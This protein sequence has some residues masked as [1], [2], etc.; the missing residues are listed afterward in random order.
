MRRSLKIIIVCMKLLSLNQ[1]KVSVKY[2]E[3]ELKYGP[4]LLQHPSELSVANGNEQI[5]KNKEIL[6]Q[7]QRVRRLNMKNLEQFEKRLM[8]CKE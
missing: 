7:L 8:N 4:V 6:E 1:S 3:L 5:R 2:S